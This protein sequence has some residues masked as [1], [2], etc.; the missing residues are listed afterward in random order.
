MDLYRKLKSSLWIPLLTIIIFIISSFFNR[1]GESFYWLRLWEFFLLASIMISALLE[2]KDREISLNY[3]GFVFIFLIFILAVIISSFF[4]R[5]GESFYWLRLWEFFLLAS[6]MISTLLETKDREISLNYNG[7]IF[8]FLIFILAVIISTIFSFYS[9]GSISDLLEVSSYVL[10]F[11]FIYMF[12]NRKIEVLFL[13]L[14]ISLGVIDAIF[15]IWQRYI[16]HYVRPAG[17][18][19]YANWNAQF[20]LYSTILAIFPLKYFFAKN[21]KYFYM[22]SALITVDLFAMVLSASRML[23]ILIPVALFCLGI[24]FKKAKITLI[25]TAI[26]IVLIVAIPNPVSNRLLRNKNKYDMQ[27]PKIW[28][29]S[30]EIAMIRPLVGVGEGA[31]EDFAVMKNFP[32]NGEKWRYKV[33]AKIAHNQYLQY[34]ANYGI[35]GIIPYLFILAVIGFYALREI[36]SGKKDNSPQGFWGIIFILFLIHSLFDNPLY[37]PINAIFIFIAMAFIIPV[38]NIKTYI[39]PKKH[40]VSYNMFFALLIILVASITLHPFVSKYYADKAEN[41]MDKDLNKAGKLYL[42]AY[43]FSPFDPQYAVLLSKY[44]VIGYKKTKDMTDLFPMFSYMN[45]ALRLAP[46]K[47]LYRDIFINYLTVGKV[48]IKNRDEIIKMLLEDNIRFDPFNPHYRLDYARLIY[49]ENPDSARKVVEK[50]V[51]YEPNFKEGKEF[52]KKYYEKQ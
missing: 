26:L 5:G 48:N 25:V 22:L 4:N 9:W 39:I 16:Y 38:I 23:F 18:L 10:L 47:N 42:R 45:I 44:W 52:L 12:K 20:I 15:V 11:F 50:A 49:R 14:F 19:R 17:F 32:V 43:A 31:F 7:F 35:L 13:S 28:K 40:S 2:T 21:K 30:Y 36:Y 6:I 41:E 29:M 46:T 1:G 37:L 24:L 27:R 3:N 51:E 34:F 33:H 8:I